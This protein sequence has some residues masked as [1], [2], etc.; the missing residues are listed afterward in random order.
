VAVLTAGRAD[1]AL[2]DG[3]E[4]AIDE[5]GGPDDAPLADDPDRLLAEAGSYTIVRSVRS[6][7]DGVV[8]GEPTDTTAVD[9]EAGRFTFDARSTADGEV[10]PAL[11]SDQL[12]G[13]PI[14]LG[15]PDPIAVRLVADDL[16]IAGVR[17][18]AQD[19]GDPVG[20]VDVHPVVR[21]DVDDLLRCQG[22]LDVRPCQHGE[23]PAVVGAPLH[24]R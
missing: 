15:D 13:P 8:A 2:P 5:G 20:T 16:D 12:S 4:T 18:P 11:Q 14:R 19:G 17:A 7:E 23:D 6:G 10:R 21:E 24:V 1:V 3:V 9:T 22:P